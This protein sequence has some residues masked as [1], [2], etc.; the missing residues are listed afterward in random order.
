MVV[1]APTQDGYLQYLRSI[2]QIPSGALPDNSPYIEMA[3]DYALTVVN[4]QLQ[5]VDTPGVPVLP[6]VPPLPVPYPSGGP[7]PT[8]Y[9]YAVYNLAA[10]FQVSYTPDFPGQPADPNTVP[11]TPAIPP[12]TYFSELR[13]SMNLNSFVPGVIEST[14]DVTTGETFVVPDFVKNMTLGN[15]QNLQ[16][17]WGRQYMALA[18]AY[19]PTI[20]GLTP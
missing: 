19:G 6:L 4:Q 15:L 8:Y 12:S 17:P 2:V 7:F 16:T 20:W 5:V 10:H 11:P 9:A 13:T 14:H 1:A 3:Y 18:Q